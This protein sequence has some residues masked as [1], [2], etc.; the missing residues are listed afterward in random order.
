VINMRVR[1]F[2]LLAMVLVGMSLT[3][4]S[5]YAKEK[6]QVLSEGE[7]LRLVP[8]WRGED[9]SDGLCR[10]VRARE[11][12]QG[13]YRCVAVARQSPLHKIHA[14]AEGPQQMLDSQQRGRLVQNRSDNLQ[15]GWFLV[16]VGLPVQRRAILEA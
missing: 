12:G 2:G 16:F 1:A 10:R 5:A 4:T 6:G 15:E 11:D 7:L 3:G 9:Q 14:L 13:R 8:V